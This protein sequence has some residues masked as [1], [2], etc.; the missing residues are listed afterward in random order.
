MANSSTSSFSR[1]GGTSASFMTWLSRHSIDAAGL[2]K[3]CF[4]KPELTVIFAQLIADLLLR[5][6]AVGALDGA[7]V[8]QAVDHDERKQERDR[9]GENAHFAHTHGVRRLDEPAIVKVL[10]KVELRRAHTAASRLLTGQ[11]FAVALG[12]ARA[13]ATAGLEIGC[14]ACRHGVSPEKQLSAV[15]CQF[16]VPHPTRFN[17]QLHSQ[18]SLGTNPL[19]LPDE[20]ALHVHPVKLITEN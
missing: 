17:W 8:L 20:P 19:L 14:G 2:R 16:S 15:S 7:E 9:G 3:L 11:Q 12:H 10:G 1:R 5:F 6:D 18:S 4:R 13:P